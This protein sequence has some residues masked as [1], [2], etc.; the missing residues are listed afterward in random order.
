MANT[1]LDLTIIRNRLLAGKYDQRD[2]A[3]LKDVLSRIGADR[4]NIYTDILAGAIAWAMS[5]AAEGN[6]EAAA[7]EIDLV[8]N[9]PISGEW[10]SAWDEEYFLKGMIGE[11]IEQA[12]VERIKALFARFRSSPIKD[13]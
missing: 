11:Y 8:H 5:D 1:S 9:V 10:N 7:R 4:K 13:G 3:L 12:P 2:E 6:L